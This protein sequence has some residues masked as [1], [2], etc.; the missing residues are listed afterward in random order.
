VVSTDRIVE[1]VWPASPPETA[2]HAVQVYVS[3]LRKALGD[4]IARRGP[5]YVLELEADTV[6]VHRFGR[7]VHEGREALGAGSHAVAA[8]TLR[9]ALS[10]WRGPALADFVYEP[11]AQAEIAR[12]D[13]LRFGALEDRIEADLALGRHVELVPEVEALVEAQP[14]RERPRGLLMRALYLSGR[15]ADA[16]AVYRST[17]E[18]LVDELGIEPGPELRELEAAILRQDESLA[19]VTPGAPPLRTRRIAAVLSVGLGEL[20][21][22]DV[23]VEDREVEDL[24]ATVAATAARHGGQAQTLADGSV[25]AVFGVP[26]AH[27]DDPLR[28]ARAAVELRTALAS[29][30]SRG[31]AAAIDVGEVVSAD[32]G[33][34][35]PPIR[36][37]AKLRLRAYTGEVLVSEATS[38]RI[39][40][41]ARLEA[42]DDTAAVLVDVPQVAPAFERRLETFVGRHR[43]LRA[44][45]EALK[46]TK[47]RGSAGAT[48]LTGPAGVGKTRL[49]RE[50]T[51]RSR[52]TRTLA[53][54]CLSYGD[55]ITY[56]PL[57]EML[58]Q[59]PDCEEREA[60]RAA[61]DTDPPAPP[62]EVA[63]HFRWLCEAIARERPLIVV[64]DDLHWAEPT[65]LDLVEDVVLRARGPVLVVCAAREELFEEA[66]AFLEPSETVR[67]VD[68]EGLSGDDAAKLLAELDG[69][70]LNPHQRAQLVETAAGNPFFLEQLAALALEGGLVER[71]LPETVRALLSA[72]IDQLG[73]GERAVLERGAVV[74]KEFAAEDVI[75][76]L[77]PTGVPTLEAHL[78][79]LVSRGFVRPRRDGVYAFR[80]ALL[81]EAVYRGAPKRLRAE[82]HER[83]A[84]RLDRDY[85]SLPELDEFVGYHL[86]QAYRLRSE[87][88]ESD[89]RAARLGEDGALRLGAAG[90]DAARRA[91]AP[92]AIALLRRATSIPVLRAGSKSE[93]LSELGM[94]LRAAGELESALDVLDR[95][96]DLGDEARDRKAA[97]RAR[98]ERAY[99]R[100]T[101]LAEPGDELLD[102]A[103]A[104]IP[105]FEAAGD[106]RLVGRALLLAGWFHGGRRDQ[107][108]LRQ[109]AAERA[110]EHYR[111]SNWPVSGAAGEI[112]NALYHGPTPALEAIDR[113]EKLLSTEALD[114][115][116]QAIVEA[117]LG[118]LAA[119]TGEFERARALIDSAIT[120][121][122]ELGQRAAGGMVTA[123]V[124]AE[125]DLLAGDDG[126]ALDRLHR[127]CDELGRAGALSHRAS[128]AGLLAEA[129]YRVGDLDQA[130]SWTEVA[131]SQAPSDDVDARVLWMPVRAKILARQGATDKGAV[132]ATDAVELA[133]TTDALNRHAKAQRDLGEVLVLAGRANEGLAAY[134][135]ALGLYDEKG[136]EVAAQQTRSLLDDGPPA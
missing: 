114:L 45:R 62:G 37:A 53:G 106:E 116:G 131:E 120:V 83:F 29:T 70:A 101:L 81:Q 84:D 134:R 112:A 30:D 48:L 103:S 111:R 82:L 126:A 31:V 11:F 50:F 6:D 73:P 17:R 21:D 24:V 22:V 124:R 71:P 118:G 2:Q 20:D 86:E 12:L 59:A 78:G 102:A 16:L 133:G 129:L 39:A 72:R 5:G 40:H 41:A 34:S 33:F 94:S 25:V 98:L 85:P 35:G 58:A 52:G 19:P 27:E 49:T 44:L 113:C 56:W 99:V 4:T 18:T 122:D 28:A 43:E 47:Q 46:R 23:E 55:G 64:F 32:R 100:V 10:L 54:R 68:L 36:S 110:L 75:A 91:D 60:V 14:L 26:V 105:A 107:N 51:Q 89:R 15:Q 92:A 61:L 1:D 67:R 123:S 95:A 130:L 57:R 97:A 104:A 76:L 115:H 7:L 69:S 128:A 42:R 79:T 74:G 80:H 119:Q 109:E 132:L 38:R 63:L 13:E 135:A 136:N 125:V 121:H 8:D 108:R 66:P 117:F 9:E 96:I 88:G 90:V 77:E 65:L 93:L 87:V 127:L 3:Q